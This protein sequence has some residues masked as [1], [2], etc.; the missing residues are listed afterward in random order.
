MLAP[1]ANVCDGCGE[2]T[3]VLR[4]WADG[5]RAGRWLCLDC[6]C[7]RKKMT[8][9]SWLV[10]FRLRVADLLPP[11]DPTTAPTLRLM[12]AVDDVRRVQIQ[13]VEAD[14]RLGDPAQS[15]RA[16][17][18][19]LYFVRLL[20]SHLHE[21]GHALCQL[22]AA[23]RGEDGENRV[24]ALLAGNR[25]ATAALKG[26]RKFFSARDYRDSL[27]CRVRNVIG[28]HYDQPAVAALLA[29]S[30]ADTMLDLTAASVGGLARMADTVVR[31]IINSLNAGDFMADETK[32][33]RVSQALDVAAHLVTFVDYLL[34]ALVRARPNIVLEQRESLVDVPPPVARAGEAVA[35]ER[36]RLRAERRGP[37]ATAP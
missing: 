30:D 17:G 11:G 27:I 1:M 9:L 24:N 20:F 35:A 8:R 10:A 37:P 22:D 16:L 3:R 6:G 26:L 31:A 12:I 36:E 14:E 28:S 18:D 19:F 4:R 23:A 34:D 33:R 13:L 2:R 32:A 7:G 21:A 29:A 25:E 5:P 15:H